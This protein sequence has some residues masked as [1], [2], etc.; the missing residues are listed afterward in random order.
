MSFDV[1]SVT[2]SDED[3]E[4]STMEDRTKLVGTTR[5]AAKFQAR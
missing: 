4:T 5:L 1:K 2:T 3:G